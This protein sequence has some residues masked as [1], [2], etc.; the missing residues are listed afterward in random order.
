MEFG[1][2]A[3]GNRSI[4]ADPR[5]PNMKDMIN[6]AVKYREAFRPFA[7]SILHEYGD[8]YF[9]HYHLVPYMEKVLKF[10]DGKGAQV[11]AVCHVDGTGRLQSVTKELNPNYWNLIEEF[12]KISNIP[13][14]LNTSFNLNGEPIVHSITDAIRTFFSCGLDVLV[15]GEFQIEK[16]LNINSEVTLN[17]SLANK[18]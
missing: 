15:I 11:P 9:E 5:N 13:I 18:A 12:R 10:K 6:K 4:L 2:R 14:V 3:L 8:E 16:N 17:E 1:Q 7:P